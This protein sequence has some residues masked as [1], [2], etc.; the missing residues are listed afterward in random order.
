VDLAVTLLFGHKNNLVDV[1]DDDNY[2]TFDI[3]DAEFRFSPV[4]CTVAN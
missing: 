3:V 4:E 2:K 1:D